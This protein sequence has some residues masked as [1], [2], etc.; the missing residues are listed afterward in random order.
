VNT[1]N[2][3]LSEVVDR[4][5]IV[6]LP[7]NGRDVAKLAATVTGVIMSNI[8][9]ESAKAIPGA[10]EI[11]ANGTPGGQQTAYKLDGANN[12]DF[13]FQRNMTFPNPDAVQ[14]FS[15]Q[16]SNY[17]ATTGNNAGAI[18]NVVTRSGTN[19]WH[20]AF[21]FV[22]NRVFTARNTFASDRDK[23]KRN[24]FGAHFGGP[25]VENK[26]FFFASWRQRQERDVQRGCACADDRHEGGQLEPR[27][28]AT[29]NA[30]TR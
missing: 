7:L 12:T 14:E 4:A 27:R 20:G 3:E 30:L 25:I 16:T 17:S 21:E 24:E 18:V 1:T 11:S 2:S 10:L 9:G 22:R 8:S 26:S 13:Y 6:E 19:E 29:G 5:R 23:L 28:T 15:I